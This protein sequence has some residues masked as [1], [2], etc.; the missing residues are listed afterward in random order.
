VALGAAGAKAPAPGMLA[1]SERPTEPEGPSQRKNSPEREHRPVICAASP[2]AISCTLGTLVVQ[3]GHA[4]HA[5]QGPCETGD[6]HASVVERG[7]PSGA[8]GHGPRRC[9]AFSQIR[10]SVAHAG[11]VLQQRLG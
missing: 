5:A 10:H 7:R 6:A 9:E 8:C 11:N 2:V 3:D 4:G 1:M